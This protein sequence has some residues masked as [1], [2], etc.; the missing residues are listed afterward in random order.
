[1]KE[2][3]IELHFFLGLPQNDKDFTK[4]LLPF[5]S[6]ALASVHVLFVYGDDFYR[7]NSYFDVFNASISFC[8]LC[9]VFLISAVILY[10]LRHLSTI[11]NVSFMVGF[12]EV[13]TVVFVGGRI[14]FQHRIEKIFFS[15]ALM[16]SF[17]LVSIFLADFSMHSVLQRPQVDTFE[18]L[19][20]Q[21][22]S[23]FLVQSLNESN[24]HISRIIRFTRPFS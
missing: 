4:T 12:L 21:N 15:V 13:F 8:L 14:R 7:Q 10:Y 9:M 3:S 16:A 2:S 24:E 5:N 1:M 20:Q 17:F 22:T 23:I 19:S 11:Q 18:K 6:Q